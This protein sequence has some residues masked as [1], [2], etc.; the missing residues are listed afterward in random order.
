MLFPLNRKLFGTWLS[1]AQTYRYI[2]VH[3]LG[4]PYDTQSIALYFAIL[5]KTLTV[6]RTPSF[7]SSMNKSS[8]AFLEIID[9]TNLTQYHLGGKNNNIICVLSCIVY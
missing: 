2:L 6:S 8:I 4:I 1:D 7:I 5:L 9:D 3:T